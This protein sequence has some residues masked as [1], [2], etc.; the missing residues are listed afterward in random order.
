MCAACAEC[1]KFLVFPILLAAKPYHCS[2]LV[3]F[4]TSSSISLPDRENLRFLRKITFFLTLLR[5]KAN[6]IRKGFKMA[7]KMI[8]MD[9]TKTSPMFEEVD[10]KKTK[11]TKDEWIQHHAKRIHSFWLQ[12][13]T[14]LGVANRYVEKIKRDLAEF[15]DDSLK[16]AFIETTYC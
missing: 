12:W 14:P 1:E 3:S 11:L 2:Q 10:I 7:D 13:Q 16:R 5:M 8:H 15:Y 9:E 4:C 6:Q